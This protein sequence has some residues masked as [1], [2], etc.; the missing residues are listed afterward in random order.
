MPR[1]FWATTSSFRC[2]I[3][4]RSSVSPVAWNPCSAACSFVNSKYSELVRSAL[5]GMHPMLTQVPPSVLSCSTQTVR[6]PNCAA[7]IA[8]T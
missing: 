7:R 6:K 3:R 4:G 5:D 1:V 2:I 8:A